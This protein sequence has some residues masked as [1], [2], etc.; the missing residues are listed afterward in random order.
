MP[1]ALDQRQHDRADHHP[2]Q[3]RRAL[4]EREVACVEVDLDVAGRERADHERG[5]ERPDA[6]RGGDADALEDVEDEMH[7]AVP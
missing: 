6:D 2:E 3:E 5:Q 1:P 4:Q 7:R